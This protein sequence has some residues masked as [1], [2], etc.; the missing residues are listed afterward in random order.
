MIFF[1]VPVLIGFKG[2]A[3]GANMKLSTEVCIY[4]VEQIEALT[5]P[6]WPCGQMHAALTK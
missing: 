2:G 4:S 1:E 5:E 6:Q 3:L